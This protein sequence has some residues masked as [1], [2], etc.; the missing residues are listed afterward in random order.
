MLLSQA[1]ASSVGQAFPQQ[2]QQ[3]AAALSCQLHSGS[4]AQQR[5]V[6]SQSA[7]HNQRLSPQAHPSSGGSAHTHFIE[8]LE[9][10]Y[11]QH[12]AS[13]STGNGMSASNLHKS[14]PTPASTTNASNSSFTKA[15]HKPPMPVS[16][17]R[18]IVPASNKE[19]TSK[20]Q[21]HESESVSEASFRANEDSNIMMGFLKS[22]R[23]SFESAVAQEQARRVR[24]QQ[25]DSEESNSSDER[26]T[27]SGERRRP[28][29]VTDSSSQQQESCSSV[30]E[31]D[32]NSEDK[33]TDAS[34]SNEDSDKD[35]AQ[36]KYKEAVNYSKGPPRKRLKS[37]RTES[38]M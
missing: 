10:T 7:Y 31:S 15:L 27:T 8:E 20:R 21:N 2:Q 23:S 13:Q 11:K 4:T 12:L 28:A 24:Q 17:K 32:W 29:T 37:K 34:S 36:E 33:K 35:D 38:S 16:H 26:P 18:A 9:K 22:L 6:P 5:H 25:E 14:N 1:A 19:P 3:P 30:D